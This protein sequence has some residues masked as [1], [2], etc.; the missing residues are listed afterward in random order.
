LGQ[1]LVVLGN[2]F[3]MK[4]NL[5]F[6]RFLT[7]WFFLFGQ[8][9]IAEAQVTVL[10]HAGSWHAT[11]AVSGSSHECS[12]VSR[13]QDG[14]FIM[15]HFTTS[16][17]MLMQLSSPA[18]RMRTGISIPFAVQFDRLPSRDMNSRVIYEPDTPE[19]VLQLTIDPGETDGFIE[20]FINS[21]QMRVTFRTGN[22]RGWIINLDGSA[23]VAEAFT[24]C[25]ERMLRTLPTTQP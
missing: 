7:V 14:R 4:K 3:V 2:V 23:A 20:E 8:S 22:E 21:S 16:G 24:E 15:I 1:S 9:G 18:W 11:Q 13:L 6:L 12:M 10:R 5:K 17:D 19:A 25:V